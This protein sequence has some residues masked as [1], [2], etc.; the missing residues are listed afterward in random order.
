LV[1]VDNERVAIS[2]DGRL[3]MNLS[4][5]VTPVWTR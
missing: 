3:R 5:G 2:V 4:Y 1:S